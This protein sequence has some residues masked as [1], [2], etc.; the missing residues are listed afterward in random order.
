VLCSITTTPNMARLKP[1]FNTVVNNAGTLILI[2]VVS[3]LLV[4][5]GRD[6]QRAGAAQ[7]VSLLVGLYNPPRAAA[8]T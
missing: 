4:R 2:P 3:V 5:L 1:V 8:V 6:G 7:V